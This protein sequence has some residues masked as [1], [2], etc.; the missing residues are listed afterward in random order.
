MPLQ[1]DETNPRVLLRAHSSLLFRYIDVNKSAAIIFLLDQARLPAAP[2]ND[3]NGIT[4][5]SEGLL[6]R[7]FEWES[8]NPVEAMEAFLT[9]CN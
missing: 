4:V 7:L 6:F 8:F 3:R 1:S 9:C 5:D 2:A